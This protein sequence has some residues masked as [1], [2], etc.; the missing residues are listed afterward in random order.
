MITRCAKTCVHQSERT[1]LDQK[2]TPSCTRTSRH[3]Y[4]VEWDAARG[5][6]AQLLQR[7]EPQLL[8]LARF[9]CRLYFS[10]VC[11]AFLEEQWQLQ[12]SPRGLVLYV[13][14]LRLDPAAAILHH[15]RQECLDY[16]LPTLTLST[17]TLCPAPPEP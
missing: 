15:G 8:D 11:D 5:P 17:L 13:Y 6:A 12:L 4:L 14:L 7:P 2:Q 9:V 16:A 1:G 10:G 3:A